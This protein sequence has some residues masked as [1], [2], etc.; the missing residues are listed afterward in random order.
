LGDFE[1]KRLQQRLQAVTAGYKHSVIPGKRCGATRWKGT[2][3]ARA[4]VIPGERCGAT[5]GKGTHQAPPT[6]RCVA[7]L[8]AESKSWRAK[9]A[10]RAPKESFRAVDAARMPARGAMRRGRMKK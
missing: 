9:R 10:G 4:S 2:H 7:A 5:R 8:G 6:E 1:N 3:L